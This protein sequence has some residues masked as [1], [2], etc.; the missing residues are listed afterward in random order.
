MVPPELQQAGLFALPRTRPVIG[1]PSKVPFIAPGVL[2]VSSVS[3]Y[4]YAAT[5][6]TGT[7]PPV[8]HGTM[9][10]EGP[11]PKV[12]GTPLI[13]MLPVAM[14]LTAVP[15]NPTLPYAASPVTK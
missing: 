9:L 3:Q 11:T 1:F 12:H 14:P 13:V 7:D 8:V 10:A 15:R 4:R 5:T 2:V 6:S